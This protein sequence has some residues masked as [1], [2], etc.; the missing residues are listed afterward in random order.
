MNDRIDRVN[1]QLNERISQTND[2]IIELKDQL[3]E[4][5]TRPTTASL[6]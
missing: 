1:D 5:L 4:R 6:S 2:R 3:N